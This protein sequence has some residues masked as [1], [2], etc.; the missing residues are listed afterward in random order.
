MRK[1][2][3]VGRRIAR[4][5]LLAFGIHLGF[6]A[7]IAWQT[8]RPKNTKLTDS[9]RSARL[10]FESVEFHSSDGTRLVGWYIPAAP[11]PRG[12]VVLCHGVDSDR[13]AMLWKAEILHKAG[14]AS[15]LFDFRG[16][17]ESAPSLCT[18]GYREVDD[19]LAAID[20]V[21]SRPDA[22]TLPLGVLG[23]SQGAAV[24]LMGTARSLDVRA[25]V[26]ESPFARLD[27]AVANHF[28]KVLGWCSPV[29]AWPTQKMGELLI[30]KRCCDVSPADEIKR[31]APRPILLIQDGDDRLC[32][33]AE[34]AELLSAAGPNASLWTVP[35][36][37]HVQ[38]EYIAQD[39]FEKRVVAFFGK[40]LKP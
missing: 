3:T 17:G 38:A 1:P 31:I 24:A 33:P 23:E 4:M 25:V 5:L 12:V 40:A 2:P 9:P 32:P 26:A 36:A 35:G 19:M 16:R 14:F 21:R 34:T 6:C 7:T 30:R 18:I 8:V 15:L 13:T 11:K 28:A 37:D 39:E 20:F 10:P 29:V 27:H 22:A